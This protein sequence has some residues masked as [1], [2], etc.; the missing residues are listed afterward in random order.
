MFASMEKQAGWG[1]D[2]WNSAAGNFNAMTNSALS[3]PIA[4]IKGSI[5]PAD[6][7]YEL[8][9]NDWFPSAADR[10][11][12]AKYRTDYFN[13][14]YNKARDA[15]LEKDRIY[16]GRQRG[17]TVDLGHRVNALKAWMGGVPP[18]ETAQSVTIDPKFRTEPMPRRGDTV[19]DGMSTDARMHAEGKLNRQMPSA[20]KAYTQKQLTAMPLDERMHAKG[21]IN[22]PKPPPFVGSPSPISQAMTQAAPYALPVGSPSPISQAMTQAAPYALPGVMGSLSGMSPATSSP[23]SL[24]AQGIGQG[25]EHADP[26]ARGNPAILSGGMPVFNPS[27]AH[28]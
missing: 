26:M 2:L 19:T 8:P 22:K 5:Q 25:L 15:S 1:T 7:S 17:R 21:W 6:S 28:A 4:H 20:G 3:G 11:E 12:N 23:A 13:N 10:A 16:Q 9:H 18:Q 14:Q 24:V 27:A